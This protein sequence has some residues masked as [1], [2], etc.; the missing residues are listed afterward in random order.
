[1]EDEKKTKRQLIEEL[2][3]LRQCVAELK[4]FKEEIRQTRINQEKFTKAFLQNSIPVGITTLKEGKFVDVSD[5]FLRLMGRKRDEV[6]GHTSI[7]IGFITVEQRASFFEE[8]NK[9]GRIENLEMVVRTKGGALRD[10]LFNAVMMSIKNEKYLLTVMTDITDRK[11]AEEALR[12][13]EGKYR[14]L[15]ENIK[16]GIFTLDSFGKFTFVNDVIVK[17]SGYPA[18]WFLGRS[19][20]NVI[21]EKNRERVQKHFNAVMDG[22]NQPYDLSY[23][24]KPGNLLHVEVSAAPLFDGAKVIG[25]LG[26]S[27]DITDR[28]SMERTLAEE[29]QRLLS[30]L[31]GSPVSSFVID[32]DHRVTAWNMVNEFFTGISKE[33]ILGKPLDLS[34]L[35]KDRVPP[36]LA[37]LVLEM[38]DEEIMKRYGHKGIRKSEIHPQAF[39]SI[40][41][42]WIKGKEHIMG[43][44]AT[45][46][47]DV[48]G[49]VI[50][51]IQCAQ[52]ITTQKRFEEKLRRSE[53][54]YRNIFEGS[55]EGIYQV[56]HGGRFITAN[57]AAARILGYESPEELIGAIT[58]IGSQVYVYPEDRDKA[59]TL[60]RKDGF[61]K[62]FEVRNR[63]KNGSIVWVLA[64][65]HIVRDDQGN[66]LYHE[67]TSRDITERK[68]AE[69]ALYKAEEKYRSIFENAPEGIFQTTPEGSFISMNPA[70]AH[71]CGYDSPGQMIHDITDI[72]KQLY[73]NSEDREH[74]EKVVLEQGILKGFEARF[75]RSD[76]KII[77]VS[78]YA[79]SIENEDGRI[80]FQGTIEDITDRKMAEEALEQSEE[81]YRNIFENVADGIFQTTLDGRFLALNPSLARMFGYNSPE[82]MMES[83]TAIGQQLYAD[84]AVRERLWTIL[85]RDDFATGYEAQVHRKDKSKFWI[86]LNVRIVRDSEGNS[87]YMEGTST[88]ITERKQAEEALK[89][90]SAY[91]RSLIEASLDPLFTI[92]MDGRI[93]DVNAAME[94]VTGYS[95]QKL[96]NTIF[97]NYFTEPDKAH[98]S[99]KEVLLNGQVH[100]YE[101]II[102]HR[103]RQTIQVLFNATVFRDATGQILGIFAAARDITVRKQAEDKLKSSLS[104]KET[105]LREIHHRVKNNLQVISSMFDMHSLRTDNQ[106]VI[107]LFADARSKI[108]SLALIHSQLYRSDRFDKINMGNH[109]R[110]LV[111][112]ISIIYSKKPS[113]I[114]PV[115]API[116]V[117]LSIDQA[118]PCTLVLNEIISNAY[119]HAFVDGENGMVKISMEKSDDGTV[120]LR[121]KDYGIGLPE[122]IDIHRTKSLG[123]KLVKTLVLEQLKGKMRINR[124][125]G[126]EIYIEFKIKGRSNHE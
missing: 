93:T 118:I 27:R 124:T 120:L 123:L 83:V 55:T 12:K 69:E 62:N 52:N 25:F 79:Q 107:D 80:I 56:S 6:I 104:E 40:G 9:R 78:I 75:Y 58:D 108:Y 19:Y 115:I 37:D 28:K 22:E 96:I 105:L 63:Q 42:I 125:G 29:H 113:V 34:P 97:L 103:N 102:K 59:L 112:Y 76:E 100:D 20:L 67:G 23:P 86:S 114:T 90:A 5:A 89:L 122:D 91:N 16:D 70:F 48:A 84:P 110:E 81:K 51:A 1:M 26:I 111:N 39:E 14:S 44:Q 117:Y 60:L 50:G 17:R 38:S 109:V 87:L 4:G 7:E 74:L 121:V 77:W 46:L 3:E 8:L 72:K 101:L 64:N 66:I 65:V 35:F 10:G 95:K 68:R 49:N 92:G 82:E 88:D 36:A 18:E 54:K 85:E 11:R 32:C 71:I 47:R 24:A 45:R 31:D 98:D 33:D 94:K 13:S 15:I 61:F 2:K 126:T 99:F 106:E 57:P 43:I 119:K 30:I 21:S 41:S 53:E 73:V 116:D